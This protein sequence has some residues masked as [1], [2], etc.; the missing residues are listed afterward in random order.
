[1]FL[2]IK[3]IYNHA[4][5]SYNCDIYNYND[6]IY[7]TIYNIIAVIIYNVIIYNIIYHV[8]NMTF[9]G[10]KLFINIIQGIKKRA[11]KPVY[12]LLVIIIL[13]IIA[14][15]IYNTFTKKYGF[16]IYS[17]IYS[18]FIYNYNVIVYTKHKKMLLIIYSPLNI[19]FI[20]PVY[21][22]FVKPSNQ[23]L[24]LVFGLLQCFLACFNVN[25][26]FITLLLP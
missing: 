15:T 6:Q 3:I 26:L 1:M 21:I 8:I 9:N 4:I 24:P 25:P 14:V 11:K 19:P 2:F 12:L 20:T 16:K 10:L 5:Y 13:I 17:I 22:S 18:S 23:F 7:N